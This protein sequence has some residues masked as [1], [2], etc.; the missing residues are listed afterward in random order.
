MP[1]V[2]LLA[3]NPVPIPRI[4]LTGVERLEDV[5]EVIEV[6]WDR[7]ASLCSTAIRTAGGDEATAT[8]LTDALLPPNAG[9]TPP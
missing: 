3:A 9:A 4:R 5:I 2:P 6:G 7:L 8:A 1:F